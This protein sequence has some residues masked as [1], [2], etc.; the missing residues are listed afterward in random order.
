MV[1]MDETTLRALSAKAG[2][3]MQ[4]VNKETKL[5]EAL[6]RILSANT[7]TKLDLVL[8]GG[9]ALNKAYFQGSQRFSEDI[10]L[11]YFSEDPKKQKIENLKRLVNS[12]EGFEITGPWVF[13]NTIRFQL[14]YKFLGLPDHVRVEFAINKPLI[15][16]N[17]IAK[18]DISS[19]ITGNTLFGVPC[20]SLDDLVARKFNALRERTQGKDIW[21]CAHAIPKTKDLKKAIGYAL[22]AEGNDIG[23]K[24]ALDGAIASL[25]KVDYIK[26]RKLTNQ[27][28]P[29]EIRPRDWRGFMPTLIHEIEKLKDQLK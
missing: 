25:K 15:T 22:K 12:L 10:D 29:L 9:T 26:I 18:V 8:K 23:V 7:E 5:F 17:P 27:Y 13:K 4:F 24:E 1:E 2:L 19:D 20:Y 28:I 11:D 16:A 6:S 14:N 21:D 3:S